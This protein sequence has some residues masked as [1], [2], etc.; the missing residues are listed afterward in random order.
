MKKLSIIIPAFNE[1]RTVDRVIK[2]VISQNSA[3]WQKEIIVVDDGSMDKTKER[4]QPFLSQIKFLEHK[5]N[6]GKGA[7]IRTGLRVV[8]GEAIII[9]DAD[10]EYSPEDWPQ[11]LKELTNS[12]T[13]VV[14]GSRNI[15]P[16]KK[17]YWHYDWSA[18]LLTFLV[19]LL[20]KSRLTDVYTGYK[21]F[22]TSLVKSINF[23][24]SGF[25]IEAEATCK[26][27]KK[28]ITIKEVPIHYFPR[29]FKEGKKISFRD[30]LIGLWTIIKNRF[31]N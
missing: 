18:K 30:G 23:E 28:G 11:L 6:Q 12:K 25:E 31:N 21:L 24:S 29:T 10:L 3:G 19:N 1:E 7:A 16:Q 9:Q 22:R 8:T 14:Y 17:S 4:V 13:M 27:L 5:Q 15:I 26:I 20:F 2:K